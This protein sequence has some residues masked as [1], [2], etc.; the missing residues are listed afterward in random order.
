VKLRPLTKM[1]DKGYIPYNG[2]L[3][4]IEPL[5]VEIKTYYINLP[6]GK[7]PIKVGEP[8]EVEK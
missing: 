5:K 3:D 4:F 8:I 7:F 1:W 2:P 6:C